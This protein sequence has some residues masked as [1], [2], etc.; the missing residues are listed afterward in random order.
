MLFRSQV[1][2]YAQ[3]EKVLEARRNI[4][5]EAYR[6]HPERFV[7]GQPRLSP[8]PEGVWINPPPSGQR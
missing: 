3:A 2:H 5:N 8:L 1:V 7:K 4:L 6:L